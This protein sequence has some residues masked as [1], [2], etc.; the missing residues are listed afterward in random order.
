MIYHDFLLDALSE[1]QKIGFAERD[2]M[3]ADKYFDPLQ[4]ACESRYPKLMEIALDAVHFL[5]GKNCLS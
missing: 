5:I 2:D 4:A 1:N 3:D